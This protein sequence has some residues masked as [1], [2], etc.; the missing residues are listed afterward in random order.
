M[1]NDPQ[2]RSSVALVNSLEYR[3]ACCIVTH[4]MRQ[5]DRRY[6]H[7]FAVSTTPYFTD[8]IREVLKEYYYRLR[9]QIRRDY[10]AIFSENE[11]S[12]A[13]Y[14]ILFLAVTNTYLSYGYEH[15]RFLILCTAITVYAQCMY[16][17]TYRE[18]LK[19]ST[20]HIFD[21]LWAIRNLSETQDFNKHWKYL[22]DYCNKNGQ[23]NSENQAWRMNR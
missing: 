6:R 23:H 14:K 16:K 1:N 22:D 17:D 4:A 20:E 15:R 2:R 9:G 11:K 13:N 10:N 12:P 18:A 3:F 5:I 8:G 19:I 21:C 7:P